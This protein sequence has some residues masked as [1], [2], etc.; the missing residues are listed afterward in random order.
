IAGRRNGVLI[1]NAQG[2]STTYALWYL[3][4]RG[5]LVI[6]PGVRVYEGMIVGEH[7]RDNDREV[8]VLRGKQLST[9]RAA[10]K[11]ESR[12]LTPP[13]RLS[14]EAA[15]AYIQDDELV[16]VTP[17]TIRLRKAIRDPHARKRAER[18]RA[19]VATA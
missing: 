19:E 16:E 6:D 15:L 13:R 18:S 10:G 7:S 5:V 4:E 8:N 17:S 3:E 1:S 11:E 14:L 2:E 9:V 12:A